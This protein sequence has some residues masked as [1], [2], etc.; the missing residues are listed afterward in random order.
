MHVE[1]AVIELLFLL[2]PG[3]WAWNIKTYPYPLIWESEA[4]LLGESFEGK[5]IVVVPFDT[6]QSLKARLFQ[7]FPGDAKKPP[8]GLNSSYIR[9]RGD[10]EPN[11]LLWHFF[12]CGFSP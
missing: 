8:V 6:D 11:Y 12:A 2:A 1:L 3:W 4:F 9:L 5:F 7:L 10:I